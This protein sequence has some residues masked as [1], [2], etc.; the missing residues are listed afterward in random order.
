MDVDGA[1]VPVPWSGMLLHQDGSAQAHTSGF[2]AGGTGSVVWAC[3]PSRVMAWISHELDFIE[4]RARACRLLWP[5]IVLN[6]GIVRNENN[7][8]QEST[9]RAKARIGM[10]SLACNKPV[11][12]DCC[13]S[14]T[15]ARHGRER[16][17]RTCGSSREAERIAL[18]RPHDRHKTA[19][20]STS[21]LLNAN[22]KP[23]APMLALKTGKNRGALMF[24]CEEE[25]TL[26]SFT[27]LLLLAC[28]MEI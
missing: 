7:K 10:K 14:T 13:A 15:R 12:C 5:A 3:C 16:G 22:F 9:A 11:L 24:L 6:G 21:Q 19:H 28:F 23:V 20:E 1:A 25:G 26:G 18:K 8:K 4:R 2:P 27:Y 17:G